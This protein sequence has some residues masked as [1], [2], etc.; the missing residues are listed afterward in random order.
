MPEYEEHGDMTGPMDMSPD[1]Q[2][3]IAQR[4]AVEEMRMREEENM[5]NARAAES[6][7]VD[8]NKTELDKII[9]EQIKGLEV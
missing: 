8:L 4:M 9:D 3:Q 6:V 1:Q 7:G 2:R 5:L